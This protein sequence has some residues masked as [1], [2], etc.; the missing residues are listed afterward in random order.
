MD[1]DCYDAQDFNMSSLPLD[2]E[3]HSLNVTKFTCFRLSLNPVIAAAITGGFLKVTPRLM[4]TTMTYIYLKMLKLTFV[5]NFNKVFRL[6]SHIA[7]AII[8][9]M[10][11][12]G[13][14][15]VVLVLFLKLDSLR[16]ITFDQADPIHQITI[17]LSFVL[18]F[19]ASGFIWCVYPLTPT[20]VRFQNCVWKQKYV[21]ATGSRKPSPA[22]PWIVVD[23]SLKTEDEKLLT[24]E[25]D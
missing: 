3:D 19:L 22:R 10:L 9:E 1:I 23:R 14:G 18:Y 21:A 13:G 20:A 11:F 17:I 7:I 6:A 16:E 12:L 2:C 24:D 8:A 15:I 5:L 4:F 25:E